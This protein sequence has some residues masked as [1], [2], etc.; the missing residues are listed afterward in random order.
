MEETTAAH[1]RVKVLSES[2]ATIQNLTIRSTHEK[3]QLINKVPL[4]AQTPIICSAQTMVWWEQTMV[5]W[6]QTIVWSG[7]TINDQ[8]QSDIKRAEK[9]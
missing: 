1:K 8:N 3:R 2:E 6:E 4:Q 5:W 7:Q 9:N